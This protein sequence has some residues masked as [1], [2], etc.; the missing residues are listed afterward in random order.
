[1]TLPTIRDNKTIF[2]LKDDPHYEWTDGDDSALYD[3]G[4]QETAERIVSILK[5]T[6]KIDGID[7]MPP[8]F[9]LKTIIYTIENE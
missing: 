4:A 6:L 5:D 8:S 2:E 7:K 9:V 3:A 1:M